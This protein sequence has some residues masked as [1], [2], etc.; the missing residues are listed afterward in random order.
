MT[1]YGSDGRG[2]G[3]ERGLHALGRSCGGRE[4]TRGGGC[5]RRSL[6]VEAALGIVGG[7]KGHG[8]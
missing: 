2:S 3:C 6:D 7:S 5:V 1:G 8:R 4:E